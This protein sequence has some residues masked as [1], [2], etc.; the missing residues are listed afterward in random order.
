[1]LSDKLLSHNGYSWRE[2]VLSC[3]I[4]IFE[5]GSHDWVEGKEIIS[6]GIEGMHFLLLTLEFQQKVHSWTSGNPLLEDPP[7]RPMGTPKV[8]NAK[9]TP[10]SFC[11]QHFMCAPDCSWKSQLEKQKT[12]AIVQHSGTQKKGF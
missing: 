9:S 5:E 8:P 12:L 1:M 6:K 10:P 3:S 7:T 11:C 2:I 4:Q